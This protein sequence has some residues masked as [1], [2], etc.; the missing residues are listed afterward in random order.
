MASE[1]PPPTPIFFY[2]IGVMLSSFAFYPGDQGH[3]QGSTN[4]AVCDSVS[5]EQYTRVR[6]SIVRC[7]HPVLTKI[8]LWPQ[9][10]G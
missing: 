6:A 7:L 8:Q 2:T 1:N 5:A 9:T 4:I 10:T 3:F